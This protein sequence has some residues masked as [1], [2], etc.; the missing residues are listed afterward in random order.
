MKQ[1]KILYEIIGYDLNDQKNKIIMP[2]NRMIT[3]I[4][5]DGKLY[6]RTVFTIIR[7]LNKYYE[8]NTNK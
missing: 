1:N 3:I 4:T 2:E 5:P 8:V 7:A 6:L